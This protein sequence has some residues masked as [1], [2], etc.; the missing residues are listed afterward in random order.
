MRTGVGGRAARGACGSHRASPRAGAL[1]CGPA[2][3]PGGSQAWS[4]VSATDVSPRCAPARP[5]HGG[6][7]RAPGVTEAAGSSLSCRQSR[8]LRRE[9]PTGQ[10]SWGRAPGRSHVR[11][12][13][14]GGAAD[15]RRGCPLRT[16][17]LRGGGS[18]QATGNR[19]GP[20]PQ[21]PRTPPARPRSRL[22]TSPRG[23]PPIPDGSRGTGPTTG[24]DPP[25]GPPFTEAPRF[26]VPA[27]PQ[28]PGTG[29]YSAG[30]GRGPG[31]GGA[32][33]AGP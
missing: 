26:K 3:P 24:S 6:G 13:P 5:A 18:A 29:S 20:V 1:G 30:S 33:G 11:R 21:P 32:L 27:T 16:R 25:L 10:G 17:V 14:A 31:G 2:S 28:R 23:A 12:G 15:A 4:L 7:H 19:G 8:A 22:S 9:P